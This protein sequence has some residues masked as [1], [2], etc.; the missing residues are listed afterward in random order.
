[1][2][3]VLMLM[4]AIL[5]TLIAVADHA[6]GRT[7]AR[8]GEARSGNF[9]YVVNRVEL[10][11]VLADPEFPEYNVTASGRF[12]VVKMTVTN[13]STARQTLASTFDTVSDGTTEY[14]V[15]DAT[16]LYV[17]EA[18]KAVEPGLSTDVAI[19]FDVPKGV[20][21]Q[22]ILLRDGR[23]AECVAIAL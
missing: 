3:G 18:T 20:D 19:V 23:L 2:A 14:G 4:V 8:R 11:D 22:S 21:V 16:W 1:M 9:A 6:D 17:G 12:V 7:G 13:V 5:A 15:D 10:T